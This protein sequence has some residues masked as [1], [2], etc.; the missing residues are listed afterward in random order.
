MRVSFVVPAFN[1]EAYVGACLQSILCEA[2]ACGEP[3]EIIV[4]NN[5]STDRTRE[6]AQRFAGVTVVDEPRKGVT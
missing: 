2:E 4:V 1:E 5:A 6:V 3:V